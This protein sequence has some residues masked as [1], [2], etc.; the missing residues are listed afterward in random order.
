MYLLHGGHARWP[1]LRG[2][3]GQ[4]Q[5]SW[6]TP[7]LFLPTG[8]LRG[9]S[10]VSQ[11]ASGHCLLWILQW[12]SA[13]GLHQNFN[14]PALDKG[15]HEKPQIAGARLSS[16]ELIQTTLRG[17]RRGGISNPINKCLSAEWEE[18]HFCLLFNP[19]SQE[20]TLCSEGQSMAQFCCVLFPPLAPSP[21]TSPNSLQ[22]C[23]PTPSWAIPPGPAPLLG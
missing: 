14:F 19:H 9:P 10:H 20:P 18:L 21:T 13:T 4:D 2:L 8:G 22:S 7:S 5:E 23:Y 17:G 12:G 16:L 1:S 6:L 15:N 3:G 11:W